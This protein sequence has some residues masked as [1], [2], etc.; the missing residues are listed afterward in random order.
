M[1]YT[2]LNPGSREQP[3]GWNN[4]MM[5]E[6]G[7]RVLFIAGQ[8]ARNGAGRVSPEG[9]VEQFARALDNV[10]AVV[11]EAGGQASD[12]GR[13]TIYVTDIAQYRAQLK[14]LGAVYRER[15][16]KHYPAMALVEVSA[17]VDLN[18]QVEIE[19]TAVI[20]R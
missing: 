2:I 12:I 6:P 13:F 7:G 14:P 10:L 15:M 19:A 18:A 8:T 3:R 11:H 4:G 1:S 16:R 17:L 5:A 20:H 9:F